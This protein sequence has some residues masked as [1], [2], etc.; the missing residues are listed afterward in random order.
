MHESIA[1]L[2]SLRHQLLAV[3]LAFSACGASV[4]QAGLPANWRFITPL[5]QGNDLLAAW[6]AGPDELYAGGHGGVILRWDGQ[7]WTTMATPTQKTITAI[8]GL[9]ASDLWAVGGDAYAENQTNRSL[10]LHFDGQQWRELPPP[11]FSGNTYPLNCVFAVGPKDVWA[12]AD[13]GTSP[14]HWDGTKWEFV[15]LPFTIATEGSFKV[16]SGVGADDLFFGGTHG[17]ILHRWKGNWTMER[18]SEAGG[19]STDIITTFWMP[20]LETGFAGNTWGH[21]LRRS[22]DGTWSKIADGGLFGGPG[23]VGI[24]GRSATDVFIQGI[25]SI[26]HYDGARVTETSDFSLKMRGQW[27]AGAGAGDRLY[28]VGPYG[29]AHE[30]MLDGPGDLSPLTVGGESNFG[31]WIRGAKPCGADGVLL[32]GSTLYRPNDRPLVYFDGTTLKP[33][34]TLPPGMKSESSVRAAI[35]G[36]RDD[37]VIAWDNELTFERG[38]HHWNGT[39]WTPLGQTWTQPAEAVDFWRSP[40]GRLHACGPFRVMVWN[41]TDAWEQSFIVPQEQITTTQLTAIWGRSDNEVYVATKEGRIL[42]FDG[43]QWQFETTPGKGAITALGGNAN[44]VYAVGEGALVWRRTASGWQQVGGIPAGYGGEQFTAVVGRADGVFAAQRT[45]GQYTGGGLGLIWKLN[46]AT[47]TLV[48]QGLSQPLEAFTTSGAGH[49]YG[50]APTSFIITDQPAAGA[51]TLVRLSPGSTD[52]TALGASGAAIRS[53]QTQTGRSM[54]A[55][56]HVSS[57]APVVDGPLAAG[58]LLAAEHWLI[59][60]DVY[61]TGVAL[62]SVQVRFNYDPARLPAG[63]DAT[64]VVLYRFHD[65]VWSAVPATMDLA[66]HW[67]TSTEE[68][69][70][71]EWTFGSPRPAESPRLEVRADDALQIVI[72]WPA[73]GAGYRLQ[74]TTALTTPITWDSVDLPVA[75]PEGRFQ[76]KVPVSGAAR[77]YRLVK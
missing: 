13:L 29:V 12:T 70:L 11:S 5:P 33:L 60:G 53:S 57:P 38:V 77:Y 75:G 51:P 73:A 4:V 42:R 47:A 45:S 28:G 10:V 35:T 8:H 41:D 20:N 16:V 52:W 14:A 76:V 39:T 56:Q 67:I 68:T 65:G 61:P 15:D 26:R 7:A 19:F 40:S 43:R 32:Y 59:R 72:S 24:W 58:V 50:F 54:V 69:G 1:R 30:F 46:G 34:T 55:V 23:M 2:N 3:W 31:L 18:K 17:Q 44:D 62:P 71:S 48:I 6:A 25:Q 21:V 9:S 49:L 36:G 27:F 37:I 22:A 63:F 66:G 74:A 64:S